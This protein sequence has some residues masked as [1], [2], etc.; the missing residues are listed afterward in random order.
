MRKYQLHNYMYGH[1]VEPP[2]GLSSATH[3]QG[4]EQTA[5][6]TLH[7]APQ[8]SIVGFGDL[9]IYRIGEGA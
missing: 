9:V 1:V 5:D 8:S 3:L 4:G 6:L 2:P 7:L